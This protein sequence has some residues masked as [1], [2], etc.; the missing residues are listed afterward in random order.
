MERRADALSHE[1]L[2]GGPL[3]L[4]GLELLVSLAGCGG[5]G[6][7]CEHV[8]A[9]AHADAPVRVVGARQLEGQVGAESAAGACSGFVQVL[10]QVSLEGQRRRPVCAASRFQGSAQS[11]S[12]SPAASRCFRA[13]PGSESAAAMWP[14]ALSTGR[15]AVK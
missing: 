6:S 1:V 14:R 12:A 3:E 9:E 10:A 15:Y 5:L 11:G 4:E 13:R 2:A 8:E 7:T